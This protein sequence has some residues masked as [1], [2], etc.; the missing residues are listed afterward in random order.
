MGGLKRGT[1]LCT[2]LLPRQRQ[3]FAHLAEVCAR[4]CGLDAVPVG[5]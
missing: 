5:L 2:R 4:V 1:L 3:Q